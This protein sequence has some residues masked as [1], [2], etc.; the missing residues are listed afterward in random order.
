[1]AECWSSYSSS[2]PWAGRTRRFVL[3]LFALVLAFEVV[4]VV[5]TVVLAKNKSSRQACVGAWSYPRSA[6]CT[7]ATSAELPDR[8]P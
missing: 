1:M 5:E 2:A 4:G 7:T 6:A 3:I 8:D